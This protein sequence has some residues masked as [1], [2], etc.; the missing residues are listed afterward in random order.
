MTDFVLGFMSGAGT[1]EGLG[2]VRAVREG[3]PIEA[4][5]KVIRSGQLSPLELDRLQIPTDRQATSSGKLTPEQSDRLLRILRVIREAEETFANQEKARRWLRRG[6]HVFGG[7]SPLQML[8]TDVG[9]R[10]VEALL[11]RIGHGIA[12]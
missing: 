7:Q 8:D 11:G 1:G 9:A 3:L 2:A 10:N 6:T 4:V 5:E 12:A